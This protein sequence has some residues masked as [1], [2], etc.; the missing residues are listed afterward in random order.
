M[1]VIDAFLTGLDPAFSSTAFNSKLPVRVH[2]ARL[3]EDRCSV[4]ELRLLS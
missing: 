1:N 4:C 3:G 2:F